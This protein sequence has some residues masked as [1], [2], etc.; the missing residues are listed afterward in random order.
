M[1]SREM[2]SAGRAQFSLTDPAEGLA[3]ECV[4]AGGPQPTHLQKLLNWLGHNSALECSP[5]IQA[6]FDTQYCKKR[7][8]ITTGDRQ[9]NWSFS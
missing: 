2:E 3:M 8:Q 5:D 4:F 1:G 9:M 7:K 6:G